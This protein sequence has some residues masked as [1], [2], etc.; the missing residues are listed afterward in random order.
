MKE[1]IQQGVPTEEGNVTE[2][3]LRKTEVLQKIF[4]HLPLMIRL[5]GKDGKTNFINRGWEQTLGWSLEELHTFGTQMFN[6]I[7]P[8][9]GERARILD[10]IGAST[11]EWHDFKTQL[12]DGRVI[13]TSWAVVGLP[14]GS[15]IAIGRDVTPRKRA[16]EA[17]RE[18]EQKYR[19]LFEN[20]KDAIYVHDLDGRYTSVNQAAEALSGYSRDEILGK[21]FVDFVAPE[22]VNAVREN[23]CRKL[24]TEGETSYEIEVVSKSGRRIPLE[25]NSRLI[26]R[27]GIPIGVQGTARDITERRRAE[28]ALRGYSRRLIEAQEEE[29]QRIARELHDQIGQIL[30]AVQINLHT[31]RRLSPVSEALVHVDDGIRVLDEALEQVRDLSL[32][33]RPSLLDDLGLFAALRWYLGRY[34]RRTG[35]RPEVVMELPQQ[36]ERFSHDIETACFRIAQEALTNVARHANANSVTIHLQA[37]DEK[38]ELTVGDNGLGFD[39]QL[40]RHGTSSAATLGLQGMRERAEAV[41]GSLLISSSPAKGTEVKATFPARSER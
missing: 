24:A 10:F 31:I 25:V 12:R 36:D 9:P 30:T 15:S 33:L 19:E 18:A 32:D 23:F 8:D 14:D 13:D 16:D 17:L 22:Y 34:A 2:T 4:D 27:N 7:V 29:R 1:Q 35:I 40:L 26:R 37:L 38:L 20:A 39:T 21:R 41:G 3:A 5:T 28:E 11:G 6:E